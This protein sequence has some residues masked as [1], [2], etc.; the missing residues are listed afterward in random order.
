MQATG[1]SNF[2]RW[3]PEDE[4]G[5]LNLLT[6]EIVKSAMGLVKNGKVY[7]LGA[8]VGPTGPKA[9]R[10]NKS[11]HLVTVHNPP[12]R[13]EADDVLV[14]HCHASTHIDALSHV[15][16]DDQLYNGHPGSSVSRWGAEKC[17]IDGVRWV[18]GR[19]ILLDIPALKGVDHLEND[20]AVTPQD[21][22][23]AARR[24]GVEV[25]PG[26]IVLVRTGWFQM[27]GQEIDDRNA[28]AFPGLDPAAGEWLGEHDVCAVG[29][30]NVAVERWSMD[31]DLGLELHKKMLRDLGGY[32][33]EFINLEELAANQAYEFLFVAAPLRI[34]GGVGSPINPLAI[35]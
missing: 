8:R 4:R 25:R 35:T 22:D 5:T 20:Y 3:G 2:G 32:L 31:V 30:D 11:W 10:R 29:S 27:Y 1:K 24:E 19:G 15:W 16:Y 21:L 34:V 6:P 12:G 7:S 26:D 14:T 18:V 23:D 13:T 9:I 28:T 17:S 33:I